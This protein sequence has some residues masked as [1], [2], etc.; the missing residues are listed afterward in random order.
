ME[1]KMAGRSTPSD[2]RVMEAYY[3]EVRKG[4]L[5][6]V[7]EEQELFK[8]YRSCTGCSYKFQA[9]DGRQACPK[10]STR[11]DFAARETL[12][13]GALRFV[14]K[15][16]KEYSRRTKGINYDSDTL[17]TLISAGNLGL[18]VAVDRFDT[19][20]GTRFL[21]Y[22]AWWIR[23]KILEELDN[24]GVVRVP[25]YRQKQLRARRKNGENTSDDAAHVTMEE[26]TAVDNKHHDESLELDLMNN[27][28]AELIYSALTDL[29]LRGRDKYIILAYFGAREDSKNL[30]QISNRLGLSS[31]RVRQIKKDT[32]ERLKEYLETMEIGDSDD[33]FSDV[34]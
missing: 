23:E 13:K 32:L 17:K 1:T 34:P 19:K 14:V 9:G 12:V 27:Y 10:C 16:A 31:E 26:I 18:L 8:R 7:A 11:R 29:E 28:G 25:A 21:T 4:D 33:V 22:A 15:V 30:R 2:D 5:L 6:K 24:M 20:R 3:A